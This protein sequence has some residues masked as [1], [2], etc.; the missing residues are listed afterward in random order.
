V[1]PR[2]R[3]DARGELCVPLVGRDDDGEAWKLLAHAGCGRRA[4]RA[5]NSPESASAAMEKRHA[6]ANLSASISPAAGTNAVSAY[7][8]AATAPLRRNV[9][10]RG[11]TRHARHTSTTETN[12]AAHAVMPVT[13]AAPRAP[14]VG[15]TSAC[16]AAAHASTGHAT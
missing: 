6:H 12:A 13:A 4:R 11:A 7:A 1:E 5:P 3:S 14:H 8:H 16:P 2:E 10:A 15:I 9:R